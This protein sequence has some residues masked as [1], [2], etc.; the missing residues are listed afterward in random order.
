MSQRN[1]FFAFLGVLLVLAA[2]YYFF[3][4]DHSSDLVLIGTVDANQM[5]AADPTTIGLLTV[6]VIGGEV[7]VFP[8]ESVALLMI[9]WVPFTTLVD[10]Q[11][12]E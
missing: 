4:A 2:I 7:A 6:T 12:Y 10:F 3:S 5:L 8:A 9:V 11:M 1:R